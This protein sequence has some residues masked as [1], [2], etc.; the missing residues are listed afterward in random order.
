MSK[1]NAIV[2]KLVQLGRISQYGPHWQLQLRKRRQLVESI[3]MAMEPEMQAFPDIRAIAATPEEEDLKLHL[4]SLK[5]AWSQLL[6]TYGLKEKTLQKFLA[7]HTEV[8]AEQLPKCK[9]IV[10]EERWSGSGPRSLVLNEDPAKFGA[11]RGVTLD[12]FRDPDEYPQ[13]HELIVEF[14]RTMCQQYP[15]IFRDLYLLN[16][17]DI[18]KLADD[19]LDK[20]SGQVGNGPGRRGDGK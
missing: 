13:L 17:Y 5:E 1:L 6:F 14:G 8:L 18:S 15:S 4:N 2:P 7:H 3:D 20:I 11:E 10:V 12:P 16:G 9:Q 19:A